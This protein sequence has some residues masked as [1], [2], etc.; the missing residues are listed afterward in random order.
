MSHHLFSQYLRYLCELDWIRPEDKGRQFILSYAL[1]DGTIKIK[2]VPRRNSGIWEGKFLNAMR[3]PLPTSDP[4]F[5]TYYTP[6]KFYVGESRAP[7][8]D[9]SKCN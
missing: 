6:D 3:L 9:R 2:E 1:F 4:N 5:P 8:I 7:D